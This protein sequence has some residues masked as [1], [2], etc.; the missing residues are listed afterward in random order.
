MELERQV[1]NCRE[2]HEVFSEMGRFRLVSSLLLKPW[3]VEV[4]NHFHHC[5]GMTIYFFAWKV[6]FLC[7]LFLIIKN[8]NNN[9]KKGLKWHFPC[10][11]HAK[12][13][14]RTYTQESWWTNQLTQI[15]QRHLPTCHF[16]A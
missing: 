14:W 1:E 12:A 7:K 11:S 13:I 9:K 10:Q 16:Q 3:E 8:N 5:Q 15:V 6:P 2:V 4:V